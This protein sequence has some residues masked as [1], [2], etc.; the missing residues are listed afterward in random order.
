[1]KGCSKVGDESELSFPENIGGLRTSKTEPLAY[2]GDLLPG[3]ML[4]SFP[5]KDETGNPCTPPRELLPACAKEY[6]GSS[7][8]ALVGS[9]AGAFTSL[10]SLQDTPGQ[11]EGVSL[12]GSGVDLRGDGG[13]RE[14]KEGTEAEEDKGKEEGEIGNNVADSSLSVRAK[15]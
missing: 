9:S 6:K 8:D 11:G 10:F 15:C 2:L 7:V 5:G 3:S 12:K 14:E 4:V 13:E 1:M